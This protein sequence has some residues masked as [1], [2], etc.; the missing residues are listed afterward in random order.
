M[1]AIYML[2]LAALCQT[3]IA[4]NNVKLMGDK[5][6]ALA[7]THFTIRPINCNVADCE[8]RK[9]TLKDVCKAAICLPV[10]ARDIPKVLGPDVL[11]WRVSRSK[12]TMAQFVGDRP[13]GDVIKASAPPILAKAD[14]IKALPV[15]GLKNANGQVSQYW[16][17]TK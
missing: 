1:K 11:H 4:Q 9:I 7:D 13:I 8:P 5:Q 12:G 17:W 15:I 14:D 16:V 2:L 3:A 6:I 10:E